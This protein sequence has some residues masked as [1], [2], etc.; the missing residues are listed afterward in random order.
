MTTTSTQQPADL[1]T[2]RADLLAALAKARH[3]LRFTARDLDDEQARRRTT[4]SALSIGGLIKHVTAM[5]RNWARFIVIGP[6]AMASNGRDF[7]DFTAEDY[8]EYENGFELLDGETLAGVL[9]DHAEVAAATDELVRTLPSLDAVQPLPKAPWYTETV[10]SARRVLLHI[11]SET[12]Q[13]SGHADII[14]ESLDGQKS[15]G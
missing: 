1:S 10:W 6:E 4:V 2:E 15:M 14:R 5:E 3:F 11:V 12:T 13:H 7:A 9:A 8:A